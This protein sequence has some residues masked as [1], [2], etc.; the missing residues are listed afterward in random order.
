MKRIRPGYFLPNAASKR[1]PRPRTIG[2]TTWRSQMKRVMNERNFSSRISTATIPRRDF[3]RRRD[4][5]RWFTTIGM[6]RTRDGND[7]LN[8]TELAFPGVSTKELSLQSE[9]NKV[10][11]SAGTGSDMIGSAQ[12]QMLRRIGDSKPKAVEI[13]EK[14]SSG[15]GIDPSEN[16]HSFLRGKWRQNADK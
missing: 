10:T 3:N 16:V 2:I 8:F 6:I 1:N 14:S 13:G 5:S 4:S 15:H 11:P 9:T 12:I 7:V